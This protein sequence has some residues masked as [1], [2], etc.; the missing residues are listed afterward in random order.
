[1]ESSLALKFLLTFVTR[2]FCEAVVFGDVN[3]LNKL[4]LNERFT[5]AQQLIM[6]YESSDTSLRSLPRNKI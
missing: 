5:G 1:M 3:T 2:L 4:I 6:T